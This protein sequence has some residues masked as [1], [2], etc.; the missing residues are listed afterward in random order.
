[1]TPT[2][3]ETASSGDVTRVSDTVGHRSQVLPTSTDDAAYEAIANTDA[4]DEEL[5]SHISSLL[6]KVSIPIYVVRHGGSNQ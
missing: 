1:M 4:L 2:R 5:S 3:G 6:E